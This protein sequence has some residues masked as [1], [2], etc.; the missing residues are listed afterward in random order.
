MNKLIPTMARTALLAT[1]IA[2]SGNA[3]EV[4][5]NILKRIFIDLSS[6][7]LNNQDYV[8]GVLETSKYPVLFID[9]DKLDVNND[10]LAG[11]QLREQLESQLTGST[12][13]LQRFFE[14]SLNKDLQINS[15]HVPVTELSRIFQESGPSAISG[16]KINGLVYGVVNLLPDYLDDKSEIVDILSSSI[17]VA[18]SVVGSDNHWARVVGRHEGSHLN[19]FGYE[20]AKIGTVEEIVEVLLEEVFAD[21]ESLNGLS[22]DEVSDYTDLRHLG[23]SGYFYKGAAFHHDVEHATGI[24]LGNEITPN[25]AHVF[26]AREFQEDIDLYIESKFRNDS[27]SANSVLIEDPDL[28]FKLAREYSIQ[29]ISFAQKILLENNTFENRERVIIEQ[30]KF[31]YAQAFEGAYRR[32]ELNQN[33]AI[34]KPEKII[35]D[36]DFELYKRELEER[37]QE[38]READACQAVAYVTAN[39][40]LNIRSEA[41]PESRLLPVDDQGEPATLKNGD[42]VT[43]H[44]YELSPLGTEWASVSSPRGRVGYVSGRFINVIRANCSIENIP[45]PPF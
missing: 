35:S 13:V 20:T 22:A 11:E 19:R 25:R 41:D 17:S 3:A 39:A 33:V 23:A 43:I 26:A 18:E 8:L 29:S 31:E 38:V 12:A 10:V 7:E 34:S 27:R 1:S 4:D 44:G 5:Q 45:R 40:G 42:K 30:L 28:F 16:V 15:A 9:P 32:V 24:F 2:T 37:A 21:R 36:N 6:L 14:T